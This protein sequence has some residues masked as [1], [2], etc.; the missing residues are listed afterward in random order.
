VSVRPSV[1]ARVCVHVRVRVLTIWIFFH[2]NKSVMLNFT[3]L[4]Y[5]TK[6]QYLITQ[7]PSW[8]TTNSD[9]HQHILNT[10]VWHHFLET[11]F[12]ALPQ[13]YIYA[14]TYCKF[15]NRMGAICLCIEYFF[16]T[17]CGVS[18][19]TVKLASNEPQMTRQ[20]NVELWRYGN[21]EGNPKCLEVNL[22]Q[23]CLAKLKFYVDINGIESAPSWRAADISPPKLWHGHEWSNCVANHSLLS[24]VI[25]KIMCATCC[26]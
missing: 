3:V 11:Q 13:Q 9:V 24:M 20:M 17:C 16:N 19:V 26:S 15:H 14:D 12:T 7:Q 8:C 22:F 2:S 25:L 23:Y 4:K 21:W 18:C 6:W 5:Q 10:V 1:R